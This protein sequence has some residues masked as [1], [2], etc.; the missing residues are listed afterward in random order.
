MHN[1]IP[2][3]YGSYRSDRMGIRLAEF[4]VDR[5][6]GTWHVTNQG[7]LTWYEFARTVLTAAPY[8]VL[9]TPSLAVSSVKE[10]VALAKAKPNGVSFA[11]A[12]TGSIIHMGAELL[13]FLSI[14]AVVPALPRYVMGPLG[15]DGFTAGLVVGAFGVTSVF[16]RPVGGRFSDRH[17]RRPVQEEPLH[18]MHSELLDRGELL[19]ALHAFSNHLRA[20]IVRELHH[21]LDEILLDE[22]R[23]DAVDE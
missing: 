23:I 3:S 1:N 5:L 11:S 7:A 6:P 17:G 12:G 18:Q 10:L 13:V 4:V 15:G 21:R 22:V 14:G 16:L 19:G 9:T 2:V 20:V 8:M